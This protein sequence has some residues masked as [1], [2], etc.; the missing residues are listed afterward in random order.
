MLEGAEKLIIGKN[1]WTKLILT[2]N[3]VPLQ[4]CL[5]RNATIYILLIRM[6]LL[7]VV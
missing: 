3:S 1:N 4:F 5:T 6:E 7:I 2:K